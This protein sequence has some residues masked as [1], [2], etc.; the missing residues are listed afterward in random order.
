M[1]TLKTWEDVFY[2][3]KNTLYELPNGVR[4]FHAE[5]PASL[6]F[7]YGVVVKGGAYFE[8]QLKLPHGTAHLLEHMLCNANS[9]L[10]SDEELEEYKFGNQERAKMY[11]NA[12]TGFFI[13]GFETYGNLSALERAIDFNYFRLNYP[14]DTFSDH[15]IKEKTV[16]LTEMQGYLKEELDGRVQYDKFILKNKYKELQRRII[17]TEKTLAKIKVEHLVKLWKTMFTSENVIISVQT[18]GAIS[19]SIL[20]KFEQMAQLV[21]PISKP[22]VVKKEKL[23]NKFEY[24]YFCDKKIENGVDVDL[25]FFDSNVL[26]D[27]LTPEQNLRTRLMYFV[28]NAVRYKAFMELRQKKGLIYSLDTFVDGIAYDWS[29]IGVYAKCEKNNLKELLDNLYS[30]FTNDIP[31]FLQSEESETWLADIIS[32]FVYPL[33]VNYDHDYAKSKST[34][35]LYNNSYINGTQL[36][37]DIAK[38]I[39]RS[40]LYE[41]YVKNYPNI[42]W[43]MWFASP[44][45]EKEIMKEVKGSLFFKK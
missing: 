6:E 12:Y 27:Q 4:L 30:M 43:R 35:I 17:G 23:E 9:V 38:K 25:S 14:L 2:K 18:P 29:N 31:A 20:K 3:T 40:D 15:I 5:K 16:V 44:Y 13:M 41:F 10:K 28:L 33:N 19:E 26:V 42:K 22:L 7:E 8:D 39:K 32:R 36:S 11:S 21:F 45:E 24:G 1:K 34:N 37:V